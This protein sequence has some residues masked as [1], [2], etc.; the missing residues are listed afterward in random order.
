MFADT[1]HK[2]VRKSL[3]VGHVRMPE[4]APYEALVAVMAILIN[5]S[6]VWPA[7]F[8]PVPIFRFLEQFGTQ[9][10]WEVDTTRPY[11][12]VGSDAAGVIVRLDSGI[13]H[14]QIGDHLG[15]SP[16]YVDD[17]KPGTHADGMMSSRQLDWGFGTNVGALVHYAIVRAS[18]LIPKPATGCLWVNTMHGSS[19]AMFSWCGVRLVAFGG[20]TSSS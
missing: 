18:R 10:A 11:H 6:T 20:T 15:A 16:S 7:M 13:R 19:R 5:Y 9:G 3:C 1:D 2:E 4:L 8:D 12:V 17:Q 14:W